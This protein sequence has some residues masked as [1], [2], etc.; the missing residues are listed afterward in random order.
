MSTAPQPAPSTLA[1]LKNFFEGQIQSNGHVTIDENNV[2]I[3]GLTTLLNKTVGPSLVISSVSM[4]LSTSSLG[5]TGVLTLLGTGFHVSLT[6]TESAGKLNFTLA[7]TQF[8]AT[9][10]SLP[11]LVAQVAPAV[12]NTPALALSGL[13]ISLDTSN[14]NYLFGGSAA[15]QI[16][17]GTKQPS[18]QASV[19]ISQS[20][21]SI[22][23]A[24]AVG[25][26][27]F[28]VSYQLQ[29]GVSLLTGAWTDSAHPLGWDSVVTALG[30]S[31]KLDLPGNIPN[32]GFQAAQLSLDLAGGKFTLT[33]QTANGAAFLL[34]SKQNNAWGFAFGAAVAG[35]WRFSQISSGLGVLD[36]L[37]FQQAYLLISS[38]TENGF[39]FPGFPVM[40]KAIDVV[41]GLN[42]G[43]EINFAS[44]T[45]VLAKTVLRARAAPTGATTQER[46]RFSAPRR[47]GI[48]IRS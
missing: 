35:N 38:F 24:L 15:W 1:S 30:L 25:T 2:A 42:F 37:V 23:G 16:P 34:A 12:T 3:S 29:K 9:S 47:T 48:S 28:T 22:S 11:K 18:I 40:T 13:R 26:A 4:T 46:H 31:P 41:P 27:N 33:G 17:L 21:A 14:S 39:Q 36:F 43:A 20:S 45:S 32:A 6:F 7:A 19:V 44:G 5:L 10:L 8:P